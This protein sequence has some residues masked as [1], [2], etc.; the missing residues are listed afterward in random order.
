VIR[1]LLSAA[2]AFGGLAAVSASWYLL[3]VA[4]AALVRRHP[5]PS[6]QP[7]TRL[8]VLVPA[9]DEER[10]VERCVSSLL[11]QAYPPDLRRLV[12]IA[13]NCGDRT[14]EVA[15]RAGA[16]V[17]QRVDPAARGKGQALR[18]AMDRLLA[19]SQPPDAVVVV[20]ADSVAEPGLLA[21]LARAA[22][23]GHDAVQAE[24][25]VLDESGS[26]RERLAAVAFLLFHRVR[27]G[28]RAALGLPAALVGNGMLLTRRLLE[29]E[30][31]SAFTGA[32]DLEQTVRL[33]LAGVE[34]HF[35]P[36][37]RVRGPMAGDAKADGRQRLRWE[38]GRLHVVRRY[39]PGLLAGAVR[40][41]DV[42]L[43]DA[44]LDLAV[45]PLGLLAMTCA[46][47]TPVAL[48]LAVSG[49]V[50]WPVALLWVASLTALPAYVL[51]GL[52]AARAERQHYAALVGA[53]AFLL[54][55][56][57][58][59]ARLSRGF[60]PTRWERTRRLGDGAGERVHVGGVPIDVIDMSAAVDRIS[61]SFG[62]RPAMQVSTVNLDFLVQAHA[63]EEVRGILGACELSVADGWPVV[64][65]G[66][67]LGSSIRRRV[68]GADLV[69][70]AVAAAAERGAGVFLL[71]GQDGVACAAA[72]RLHELHPDLRVFWH[73]PPVALLDEIDD[74]DIL[75]RIEA[76]GAELLLVAFGHPKQ[77]RWIARNRDRL[78]VACA[79]GVGCCLDLIAG[80]VSRAPEWMQRA[81]L[82]WLFRLQQEPVRLFRRYVGDLAW[83]LRAVPRTLA[84]RA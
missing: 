56:I 26:A 10:L 84:Q 11:A 78:P 5:Q 69:P 45:P 51:V 24:Y 31:W 41:P 12:V 9:H 40:R 35:A 14:A 58:T 8:A 36:D 80:R 38:G 34:V 39:L 30:P 82:E 60:D 37:A 48:A 66:R 54:R 32:E 53:P 22:E 29:V 16:E 21:G 25:L 70:R 68:P 63:D 71:G 17:W 42:R 72:V 20:D 74:E 13:D 62:R 77:E 19:E 50:T 55:K 59:Y 65:L 46:S 79:I 2:V 33:R 23:T 83:L 15:E 6:G 44:A 75:A 1:V 52:V 27:F 43:L 18:W 81:G 7:R 67:L 73:Q 4:V 61:E 3:A 64:L 47:G 28:G 76:S 49:L 57:G